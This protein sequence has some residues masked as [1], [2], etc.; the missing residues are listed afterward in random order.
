MFPDPRRFYCWLLLVIASLSSTHSMTHRGAIDANF[1]T[2]R[3]LS[4][5]KTTDD[6]RVMVGQS[7]DALTDQNV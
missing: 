6:T 3:W 5:L 2:E 4:N 7:P 1:N